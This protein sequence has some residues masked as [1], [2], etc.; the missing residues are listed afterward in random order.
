M[1]QCIYYGFT[2]TPISRRRSSTCPGMLNDTTIMA[3]VGA[4]ASLLLYRLFRIIQARLRVVKL[5]GPKA[6]SWLFV[7]TRE[8]SFRADDLG[9]LAYETWAKQY[10][11]VY[12]APG[13]F[14]SRRFVLFDPK[15]ISYFYSKET[16]TFVHSAFA[17]KAIASVVCSTL[18]CP[19]Y[20]SN[21]TP[22]VSS[23]TICL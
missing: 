15:A 19:L 1:Q 10:G 2:T 16:F 14:G 22:C 18:W 9:G 21:L 13:A 4:T 17:K 20:H 5:K 23:G 11:D 7:L 8:T 3:L 6:A 12:N